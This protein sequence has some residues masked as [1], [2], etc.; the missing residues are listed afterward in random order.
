MS[1]QDVLEKEN[2]QEKQLLLQTEEEKTDVKT[3]NNELNIISNEI[4]TL[5]EIQK[6]I[7]YMVY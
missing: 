1:F 7:N 4:D 2:I 5:L 3:N 6:D